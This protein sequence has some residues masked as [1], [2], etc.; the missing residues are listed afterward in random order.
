MLTSEALLG[1]FKMEILLIFVEFVRFAFELSIMLTRLVA[2][3]DSQSFVVERA[4][5]TR[6]GPSWEWW[7]KRFCA[8]AYL[9]VDGVGTEGARFVTWVETHNAADCKL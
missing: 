2:P 5:N 6:S 3:C 8:M 7:S 4:L 9:T 1:H